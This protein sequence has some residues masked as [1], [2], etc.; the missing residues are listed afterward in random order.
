MKVGKI[1]KTIFKERGM[2]YKQ[3]S[4]K[5]G[6]KH[7]SAVSNRLDDTRPITTDILLNI[8]DELNCELV[9]RSTN[10][11]KMEWVVGRTNE[12]SEVSK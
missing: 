8:L 5:L 11:D 1:V 3:V 10:K 9:I 2:S 6:Y 7:P 4:E 12:D